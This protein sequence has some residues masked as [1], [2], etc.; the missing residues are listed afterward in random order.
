MNRIRVNAKELPIS[1]GVDFHYRSSFSSHH[2]AQGPVIYLNGSADELA[3]AENS[4]IQIEVQVPQACHLHLFEILA[5]GHFG[6]R[7]SVPIKTEHHG[8]GWRILRKGSNWALEIDASPVTAASGSGLET[9]LVIAT[10]KEWQPVGAMLTP[11][12]LIRQLDEKVSAGAW[13]A[14]WAS[15]L[16]EKDRLR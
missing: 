10:E 4:M 16:V 11:E 5:D 8:A 6:Y 9:L 1:T 7:Q 3:F 2:S 13:Q 12:G 14:D 15:Y